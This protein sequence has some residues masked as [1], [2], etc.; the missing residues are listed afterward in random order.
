MHDKSQYIKQD[1]LQDTEDTICEQGLE[2]LDYTLNTIAWLFP[3][4]IFRILKGK[5]NLDS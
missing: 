3:Q 1:M 4:I 2:G 5:D